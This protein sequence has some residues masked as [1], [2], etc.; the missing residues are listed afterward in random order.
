[1]YEVPV[2]DAEI[3][4][5]RLRRA[6]RK[7]HELVPQ[8]DLHALPLAERDILF[9]EGRQE[10]VVV[11]HHAEIVRIARVPARKTLIDV[12]GGEILWPVLVMENARV[13]EFLAD[14]FARTLRVVVI[15]IA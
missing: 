14:G 10:E 15:D 5:P 13:G 9:H 8:D 7:L 12:L 2:E 6:A 1:L 4:E 11:L 3:A